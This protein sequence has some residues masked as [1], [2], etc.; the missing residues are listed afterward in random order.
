MSENQE[1]EERYFLK[2]DDIKQQALLAK[3]NQLGMTRQFGELR[4]M[5]DELEVIPYINE[6]YDASLSTAAQLSEIFE[7]TENE[8]IENISSN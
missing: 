8:P 2:K 1:S 5:Q 7:T 3:V 6:K 4:K